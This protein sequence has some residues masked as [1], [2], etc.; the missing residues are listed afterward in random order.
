MRTASSRREQDPFLK[1]IFVALA[2]MAA[3][4]VAGE[5]LAATYPVNQIL[6]VDDFDDGTKPNNLLGATAGDEE[7][8]GG[9]IP[10]IEGPG[11]SAVFGG[12]GYSV[13]L[14]YDV[15]LPDSFSFFSSQ[16]GLPIGSESS[17]EEGSDF[18]KEM[19][20]IEAKDL[21]SY[22]YISLWI[23]SDQGV[24]RFS[25][26]LHEDTD[27]DSMF[28]LGR[29]V[30]DKI[31]VGRFVVGEDVTSWRKVVIPLA[32]FK[33]ISTWKRGME[34]V[35]V[36]E[37]R[38]QAGRG[39]VT[40]DDLLFGTNFPDTLGIP[41]PYAIDDIQGRVRLNDKEL[42][43]GMKV[44][45]ANFLLLTLQKGHPY[46]ERVAIEESQDGGA[47]WRVVQSFYEHPENREYRATWD[48]AKDVPAGMVYS[49]RA[50]VS[51]VWGHEVVVS[52]PFFVNA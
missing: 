17:G 7:Y 26:E 51:D 27:G 31:A 39:S 1:K 6:V 14:D 19:H 21:S 30:S 9:C 45:P 22:Q 50:V 33:K 5:A 20:K 8:P 43:S 2:A 29:D 41:E 23:L 38:M 37:N 16:L 40:T 11:G 34:V 28:I 18:L 48:V 13:R 10:S 42:R 46:L 12:K 24:P 47:T 25:I 44:L 3:C 15:E 4:A 36:F 49:L 35:L 52:G 32:R